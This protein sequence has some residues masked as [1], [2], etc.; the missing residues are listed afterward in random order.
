MLPMPMALARYPGR[1]RIFSSRAA[2]TATESLLN[3]KD[4]PWCRRCRGR[5]V[6]V[7]QGGGG[8]A[9]SPGPPAS[10]ISQNG[11]PWICCVMRGCS[12]ILCDC[13]QWFSPGALSFPVGWTSAIS[14]WFLS[15]T[16]LCMDSTANGYLRNEV[17]SS[18]FPS[19]FPYPFCG[20]EGAA[21]VVPKVNGKMSEP[22]SSASSFWGARGAPT[23]GIISDPQPR[24]RWTMAGNWASLLRGVSKVF[25]PLVSRG[26][27]ASSPVGSAPMLEIGNRTRSAQERGER[28]GKG[29]Y[30]VTSSGT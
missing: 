22:S 29:T 15:T 12:C 30:C 17:T 16:R 20:A 28:C 7:S 3:C 25:C 26:L 5:V 23:A 4:H 21:A 8:G 18:V 9:M 13:C 1:G 24:G 6:L 2:G 10:P 14:A 11:P 19:I 27:L